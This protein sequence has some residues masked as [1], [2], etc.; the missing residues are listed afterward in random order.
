MSF[1]LGQ[2][3]TAASRLWITVNHTAAAVAG[4]LSLTLASAAYQVSDLVAG[5]D[6]STRYS[7]GA[8]HAELNLPAQGVLV[9]H[10][11]KE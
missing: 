6:Y 11:I 3:P 5:R 10:I 9:L 1:P 2:K 7:D 8:V 4:R